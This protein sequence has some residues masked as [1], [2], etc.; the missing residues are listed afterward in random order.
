MGAD[1]PTDT[2]HFPNELPDVESDAVDVFGAAWLKSPNLPLG[3][4]TPLQAIGDQDGWLVR[5]LLRE[6]KHGCLS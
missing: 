4:R 5:N 1:M 6:T 2:S 3:G